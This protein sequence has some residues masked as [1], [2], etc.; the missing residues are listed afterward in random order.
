MR[1]PE[2]NQQLHLMISISFSL[3]FFMEENI[4]TITQRKEMIAFGIQVINK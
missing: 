4:T 1:A 2:F 3:F